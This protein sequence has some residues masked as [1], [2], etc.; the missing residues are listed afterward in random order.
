MKLLV[1]SML[2]YYLLSTMGDQSVNPRPRLCCLGEIRSNWEITALVPKCGWE[3]NFILG[4]HNSYFFCDRFNISCMIGNQRKTG[5]LRGLYYLSVSK[6]ISYDY[7]SLFE[8]IVSQNGFIVH[9][10]GYLF[11]VAHLC[12]RVE[13]GQLLETRLLVLVAKSK[14]DIWYA[15]WLL[16]MS[17]GNPLMDILEVRE[18]HHTTRAGRCLGFERTTEQIKQILLGLYWLSLGCVGLSPM[19]WSL[20]SIISGF[21]CSNLWVSTNSSIG[22][23]RALLLLASVKDS[24]GYRMSTTKGMWRL[25]SLEDRTVAENQFTILPRPEKTW[26]TPTFVVTSAV[27]FRHFSSRIAQSMTAL[28]MM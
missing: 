22:D 21:F 15:C 2:W 17:L 20:V 5:H 11:L 27:V 26:I 1:L 4:N 10:N 28:L 7:F 23:P 25:I 12:L 18:R 19:N 14:A 8:S 3:I 9:Y 16:D 13:C 24:L 6:E